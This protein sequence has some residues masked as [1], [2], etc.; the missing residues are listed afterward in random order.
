M[1]VLVVLI[2]WQGRLWVLIFS[3]ERTADGTIENE[4]TMYKE[5]TSE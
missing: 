5:G 1:F 4:V 2:S 3:R